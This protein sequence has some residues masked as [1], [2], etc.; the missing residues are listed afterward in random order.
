MNRLLVL[1][2]ALFSLG[3]GDPVGPGPVGRSEVRLRACVIDTVVAGD[4]IFVL[5]ECY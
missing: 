1:L 3:C 5:K 4:R 2:C